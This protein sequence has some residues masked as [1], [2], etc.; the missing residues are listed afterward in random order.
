[1]SH[2]EQTRLSDQ[3]SLKSF[4]LNSSNVFSSQSD[5]NYIIVISSTVSQIDLNLYLLKQI[6]MSEILVLISWFPYLST[7]IMH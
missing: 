4:R 6:M 5:S 1:M 2:A 7:Q 3:C